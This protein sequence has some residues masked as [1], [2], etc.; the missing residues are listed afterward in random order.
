LQSTESTSQSLFCASLVMSFVQFCIQVY[1]LNRFSF[2]VILCHSSWLFSGTNETGESR[3]YF[4][5]VFLF[6]VPLR[7]AETSPFR[8]SHQCK[9]FAF[10]NQ[11][12]DTARGRLEKTQLVFSNKTRTHDPSVVRKPLS[13]KQSGKQYT[14]SFRR[15]PREKINLVRF[16]VFERGSPYDIWVINF[17]LEEFRERTKQKWEKSSSDQ[18]LAFVFPSELVSHCLAISRQRGFTMDVC[19]QVKDDNLSLCF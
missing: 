17:S 18:R 5:Y 9:L 7:K 16:Y 14:S 13:R 1:F 11:S 3:N 10:Y 4:F 15:R 8:F 12:Q 2:C 19:A 6:S